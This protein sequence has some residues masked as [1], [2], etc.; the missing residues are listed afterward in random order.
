[1]SSTLDEKTKQFRE[2]KFRKFFHV[3]DI[4]GN[5]TVT[6]EDHVEMGE[7]VAKASGVDEKKQAEIV[8]HFVRIW[9][10]VYQK[11]SEIQQITISY[12]LELLLRHGPVGLKEVCDTTNPI[13]FQAVDTNG[14]GFIQLH[15]FAN[16]YKI[17]CL[18]DSAAQRSFD[19]IDTDGDGVLSYDEFNSALIE[20]FCSDDPNS[21]H[22]NF[23]GP[24]DP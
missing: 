4:D 14:D 6:K 19:L 15:E 13:L 11:D 5:G 10:T 9:E 20:F 16:Y 17:F 1:M 8:R 18:D 3:L 12:F 21:K 7:R 22:R 2:R 23:F 24:I